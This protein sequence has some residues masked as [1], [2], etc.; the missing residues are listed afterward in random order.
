VENYV[1]HFSNFEIGSAYDNQFLFPTLK[2][3]YQ[4]LHGWLNVSTSVMQKVV[5]N[6][7]A[8]FGIRAFEDV[9]CFEQVSV[10]FKNLFEI[11]HE[12]FFYLQFAH[13]MLIYLGIMCVSVGL[14]KKILFLHI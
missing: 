3:L 4:K 7:N 12:L 11:H 1:G 2:N 9:I 5:C 13:L 6:T 8:I 14:T 10:F